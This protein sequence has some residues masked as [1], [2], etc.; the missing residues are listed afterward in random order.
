[1]QACE[2]RSHA[3]PDWRDARNDRAADRACLAGI[4]TGLKPLTGAMRTGTGGDLPGQAEFSRL[5]GA[6]RN[7]QMQTAR[8]S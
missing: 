3:A 5:G 8:V 4:V 2:T 1:M 6:S 7:H